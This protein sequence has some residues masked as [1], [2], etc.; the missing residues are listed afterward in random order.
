MRNFAPSIMYIHSIIF[1]CFSGPVKYVKLGLTNVDDPSSQQ[2]EVDQIIRH[3]L[4]G[5]EKYHDI[6]L[7]K[8]VS[9]LEINPYVRPACLYTAKEIPHQSAIASGWGAVNNSEDFSKDLLKVPLEFFGVD[10]CNDTYRGFIKIPGSP[11]KQ[12]IVDD[13]M[14][15]A[16]SRTDYKDTCE[17]SCPA[18]INFYFFIFIL[19][20]T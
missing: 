5:T 7:L 16:G 18:K 17:V 15:C 12:G 8:L 9:S 20:L 19:R 1:F 10:K 3:P 13:T 14:I 2:V 11:L 6:G 4:Y